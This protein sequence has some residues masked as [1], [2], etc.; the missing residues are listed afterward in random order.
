[1]LSV[2]TLGQHRTWE[3]LHARREVGIAEHND[4][5]AERFRDPPRG[6]HDV[7]TLLDRRRRDDDMRRVTRLA[8]Q[9]SEEIGLLDFRREAGA[10]S[11]ALY[12]HDDERDLGHRG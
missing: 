12:V 11:A 9:R 2:P 5:A 8:E 4:D 1:M 3:R 7:K 6:D 10:W